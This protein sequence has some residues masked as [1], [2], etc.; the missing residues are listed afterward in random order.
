L[1]KQS[2]FNEQLSDTTKKFTYFVP[3][4]RA[5]EEASVDHPSAIK[6]L[7]MPEYYYHVRIWRVATIL[8]N[9]RV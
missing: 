3:R 6:K 4:N 7:F 8:F 9:N 5:W 2:G 1:G